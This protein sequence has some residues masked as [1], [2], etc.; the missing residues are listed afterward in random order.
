MTTDI[1][2]TKRQSTDAKTFI[3]TWQK[4]RSVKEV[5][6]ALSVKASSASQRAT[7]LRR[8]GVNLKKMPRSGSAYDIEELKEVADQYA[9][10]NE[11]TEVD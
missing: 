7:N 2:G 9:P 3:K 10:G 8:L 6:E 1:E 11:P 5:A 4:A